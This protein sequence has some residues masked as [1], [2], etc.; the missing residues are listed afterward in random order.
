MTLNPKKLRNR[1]S[2][3]TKNIAYSPV[4]RNRLRN[5]AQSN[6]ARLL[7][8]YAERR[9]Y[10]G[11]LRRLLSELPPK[12]GYFAKLTI[13]DWKSHQGGELDLICKGETVFS[14]PV[15][16]SVSERDLELRNFVV[17][18]DRESDFSIS[19]PAQYSIQIGKGTFSTAPQ[20]NYDRRHNILND[21][22]VYYSVRGNLQTATSIIFS[23][24]AYSSPGSSVTYPVQDLAPISD[25]ELQNGVAIVSFQDRYG[26]EGTFMTMDS[27]GRSVL[28][29]VK[30]TISN[31]IE[32][33]TV[34]TDRVLFFGAGKGASTAL[35]FAED[36]PDATLVVVA[37]YIDIPYRFDQL[38]TDYPS[39]FLPT[40]VQPKQL[41]RT[42]LRQ[43]RVIH[44]FYSLR[45]ELANCSLIEFAGGCDHLQKYCVDARH[46]ELLH[47]SE[48]TVLS[49]IRR[50]LSQEPDAG[51]PVRQ[52]NR[53]ADMDS[54]GFQFRIDDSFLPSQEI[55]WYLQM[56]IGTSKHLQKLTDHELPFVKFTS[57]DQR[58]IASSS[59]DS[60]ADAVVGFDRSSSRWVGPIRDDE[61][62][63]SASQDV[64]G[65]I[66]HPISLEQGSPADYCILTENGLESFSYRSMRSA[67]RLGDSVSDSL[68][69]YLVD[70]VE[71]FDLSEARFFSGTQFV[72]AV[73][74]TAS[75]AATQ[76]FI[77]RIRS[78]SRCD[79]VNV[80]S[81]RFYAEA[82]TDPLALLDDVIVNHG[83]Q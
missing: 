15:E 64:K 27:S 54:V 75:V 70:S 67:T 42:Y 29:Q 3:A 82:G 48:R 76:I 8:D 59:F 79:T 51:L 45:D 47:V 63:L 2:K 34:N 7:F 53:Y 68:D 26:T 71:D 49:I 23:F 55:D 12:D 44:Y 14:C 19:L 52:I 17:P 24:P 56:S 13:K 81:G 5:L 28:D 62:L 36:H 66:P 80:F 20:A 69:V 10:E 41:L 43:S 4:V 38:G 30:S 11:H 61:P 9:G 6:A 74:S 73:S 50:F 65:N 58:L 37:P 32:E 40:A 46:E 78:S 57:R 18:S 25:S 16:G 83:P 33:A 1:L 22:G 31:L 60:Y 21:H 39:K 72:A 77:D 35:I